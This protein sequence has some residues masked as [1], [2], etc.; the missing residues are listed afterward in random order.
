[1]AVKNGFFY[2][3]LLVVVPWLYAGLSR[4]LFAT[5]RV[6]V[7][8]AENLERCEAKCV[9]VFW[10]YSVF[11]IIAVN[12]GRDRGWAA[13]VS[14]S[15][16]AEFV[17][18]ILARQGVV[19]VRGSR[20][21]GGLAAL[22]GLIGLMHQGYNAV[23]VADGSKGPAKVMQAGAI[24]LA[25]KSAAPILPM[26]VA[27]DRY[28]TFRSWD[29]TLLPKPFARLDLWYGEPLDVPEKVGSEEIEQ[30]RLEM[31]HRLNGLYAQAWAELDKSGHD[32][33]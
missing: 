30:C 26:A 2:R 20:H 32:V 4:M 31:E 16:D 9:A 29:R 24:L 22:K 13:M 18:R 21:R 5:C 7:H 15:D 28:W 23:I 27:A 8:G 19:S 10:H 25:S 17:A 3:L 6:R 1:M 33:A 14:A 11:P 12:R